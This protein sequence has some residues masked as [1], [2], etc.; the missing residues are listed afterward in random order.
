M[1]TANP[2]ID[3]AKQ[4]S[5]D[6]LKDAQRNAFSKQYNMVLNFTITETDGDKPFFSSGDLTWSGVPYGI[7]VATEK[8]LVELL[9]KFTNLGGA[10]ATGGTPPP[11]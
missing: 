11:A 5:P 3:A 10:V 8:L 1:P 4:G 9:D 6:A 2:L 7:V